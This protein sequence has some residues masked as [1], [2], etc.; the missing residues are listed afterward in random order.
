M[1][2]LLEVYFYRLSEI[3]LYKF[4]EYGTPS[5][6]NDLDVLELLL[7]GIEWI[8]IIINNQLNHEN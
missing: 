8:L 5:L 4:L 1:N 3:Y 7:L 6:Y 2:L